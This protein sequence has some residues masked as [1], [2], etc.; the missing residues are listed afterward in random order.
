V[1]WWTN[2][3]KATAFA[4]KAWHTDWSSDGGTLTHDGNEALLRHVGNAMKHNTK[5]RDDD[6]SFL[7]YPTK[8]GPKSPLKIDLVYCAVLSW[9]ARGDAIESGVMNQRKYR[10]A[11]W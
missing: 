2:R 1:Q 3:Y 8:A 6:G 4:V 5:I 7:W 11:S 10:T 9:A